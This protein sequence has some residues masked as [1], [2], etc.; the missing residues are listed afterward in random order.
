[1]VFTRRTVR[2]A[3]GEGSVMNEPQRGFWPVLGGLRFL[4]AM[5]VLFDHTYNVGPAERAIPVLTRSG[6]MA[7]MCFFVIS[8][9]SIHHS[10]ASRPE[11][12]LR[13]RVLRILPLNV[14]A[15]A[16]GWLAWSVFGAA[17]GYLVPAKA[18][19][20]WQFIGCMLL[21]E[22][23][24][25]VMI[26]FLYPAWSLS[27]E[28]VYYLLAPLF[29]KLEDRP[30]IPVLMIVSGLCFVGWPLFRDEYV[31]AGN[32]YWLTGIVMLWAWLAGWV[33]YRQPRDIRY[34][35]G[36]GI[37]GLA[38]VATQAKFFDVHHFGSA[39]VN[40]V[41]WIGTLIVVFYRVGDFRGR[42]AAVC[43]YVGEISF[44]LYILHYP[45]LF[46]VTASLFRLY[47]NLNWGISQVAISLGAAMLAYHFVDKPLRQSPGDQF[48]RLRLWANGLAFSRKVMRT[49]VP[50]SSKV[51]RIELT[52]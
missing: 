50:G 37:A 45:V 17:G 1:M 2:P 24:V 10:I 51:S 48:G 34:V 23:F 36:L 28:A 29:R 27:I 20:A 40:C 31:A 43:D 26:S 38:S 21:L 32:S 9:F 47:P 46:A 13:R 12:Y 44:P 25:P 5:W 16:I 42:V 19:T 6:L 22:A 18:P 41:A 30:H 4:L 11:G 14:L 35:V 49:G 8:G 3:V 15:V 39:A 52:R 7:V 33:A